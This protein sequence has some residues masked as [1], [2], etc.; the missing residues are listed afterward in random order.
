MF[1]KSSLQTLYVCGTRGEQNKQNA[2]F[3]MFQHLSSILTRAPS[4][5]LAD[6]L[7]IV[8]IFAVLIIGL[9]LPA[10]S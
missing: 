8:A 3:Q 5:V 4:E 2:G 6:A 9:S 10:F 1:L 7:G